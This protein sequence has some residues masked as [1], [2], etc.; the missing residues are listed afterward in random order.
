[1]STPPIDYAAILGDLEAKRTALDT[2][3]A[4]VRAALAVGSLGQSGDG[5]AFVGPGLSNSL[6]GGEVPD[7]AFLGKNI[8]DAAK[9]YLEIVKKKQ[10]SKEIALALLKGGM[11]TASKDFPSIV[12][13]ILDRARK[14]NNPALVKIGTQWGLA[15]W[16][17]NL[18]P[19]TNGHKPAKKKSTASKKKI[20]ANAAVTTTREQNKPNAKPVGATTKQIS[21][22]LKPGVEFTLHEIAKAA[23]IE[24]QKVNLVMGNLQRGG[25]VEKTPGGKYRAAA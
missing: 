4:S 23:G 1:M 10:T 13:A 3:I 6:T 12:H 16:Y 21:D 18:T 20:A 14:G 5:T 19:S 17:P 2:A 25:K 11:E 24:L 7:G 9:L 8:P 22:V 15:N